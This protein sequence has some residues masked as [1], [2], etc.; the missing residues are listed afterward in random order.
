V[1]TLIDCTESSR[2]DAL[3]RPRLARTVENPSELRG[4]AGKLLPAIKML[5][6][7]W[8]VDELGIL[9]REDHGTFPKRDF[10]IGGC[11]TPAAEHAAPSLKRPASETLTRNHSLTLRE[12]MASQCA[13]KKRAIAPIWKSGKS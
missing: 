13:S 10:L 2:T 5:I 1:P 11:R 12:F 7:D 8:Y 9:T 6:S 3:R 4:T